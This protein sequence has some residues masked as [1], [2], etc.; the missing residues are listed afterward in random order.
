MKLTKKFHIKIV[1]EDMTEPFSFPISMR[2]L[3]IF[4]SVVSVILILFIILIVNSAMDEIKLLKLEY[5]ENQN[6]ELR[7][8]VKKVDA[9]KDE[10]SKMD[11][12]VESIQSML[13]ERVKSEQ[14]NE[15]VG[16]T[17]TEK[18][19]EV[20]SMIPE[21]GLFDELRDFVSKYSGFMMLAPA[22]NP[23]GG[24]WVSRG[25]GDVISA[26]VRHTGID[27]AVPEGTEVHSTMSGRVIFA[28]ADETYGNMVVIVNGISGYTT[29]YGHN[30]ELKI[31]TGDSVK[32]GDLV[33]LSGNTG[34]SEAPHLHY[35]IRY[36][37]VP[38][39]PKDFLEI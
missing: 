7:E 19:G 6:N 38:V 23:V 26:E 10:L 15:T 24:G 12:K 17:G 32:A 1:P 16:E 34:K 5:L 14:V 37:G 4:T 13:G 39:D 30:S 31:K 18:T 11:K 9:L 3:L 20:L 29:I 22:G 21:G 35:E 28:G 33:A 36:F 25:F 27:L 2:R 8:K